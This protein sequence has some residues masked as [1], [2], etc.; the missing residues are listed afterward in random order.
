MKYLVKRSGKNELLGKNIQDEG[1]VESIL[2][3][4]NDILK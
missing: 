4:E 3:V 1:D 2:G